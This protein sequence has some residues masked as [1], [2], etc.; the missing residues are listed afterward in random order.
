MSRFVLKFS[1]S[2]FLLFTQLQVAISFI[3]KQ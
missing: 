1:K 3:T 2:V